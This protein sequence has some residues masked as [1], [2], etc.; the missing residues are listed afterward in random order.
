MSNT[1]SPSVTPFP[2]IVENQQNELDIKQPQKNISMEDQ[3]KG[4]SEEDRGTEQPSMNKF[5][6]IM[7]ASMM[8]LTYWM[9]VSEVS[10]RKR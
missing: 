5:Q 3:E 10:D 9:M 7:L 6:S 1:E 8:M 2:G 4:L